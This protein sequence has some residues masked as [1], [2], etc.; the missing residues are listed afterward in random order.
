MSREDALKLD[1]TCCA[2]LLASA[3]TLCGQDA[4]GDFKTKGHTFA[5]KHALSYSSDAKENSMGKDRVVTTIHIILSDNAFDVAALATDDDPT[6][7][8]MRQA[9]RG[10]V[11]YL[12][13]R[14]DV[15]GKLK[16]LQW[17]P[18]FHTGLTWVG[19]EPEAGTLDLSTHDRKHFSGRIHTA[20]GTHPVDWSF[21]LSFDAPLVLSGK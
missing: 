13:V 5:L 11:S 16:L 20:P 3:R 9:T 15:D 12:D 7:A 6:R 21:D 2:L 10:G 8:L 14:L 19:A 1:T 4:T 17:A 18:D